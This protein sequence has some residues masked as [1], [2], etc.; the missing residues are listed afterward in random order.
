M[1]VN[2]PRGRTSSSARRAGRRSGRGR[3][4]S[5]RGVPRPAGWDSRR[6]EH[7]VPGGRRWR[8]PVAGGPR[9]RPAPAAQHGTLAE[10]LAP[11]YWIDVLRSR[12]ALTP[13]SVLVC[14]TI[15]HGLRLHYDIALA[16]P[17][18]PTRRHT[19]GVVAGA[20]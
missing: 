19:T 8:P 3:A 10:L 13:G 7:A 14:G 17:H 9:H 16:C 15:P 20:H 2:I 6:A 4:P 5:D 11:A 12:G 18:R 1:A